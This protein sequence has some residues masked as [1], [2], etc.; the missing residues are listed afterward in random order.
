MLFLS[1]TCSC[2]CYC[3]SVSII[4]SL[5]LR[6]NLRVGG[7]KDPFCFVVFLFLLDKEK[8][9]FF[10]FMFTYTFIQKN[11]REL[12]EKI[13]VLKDIKIFKFKGW[14]NRKF[15]IFFSNFAMKLKFSVLLMK[16]GG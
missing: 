9:L 4:I 3:W 8:V 13:Y 7:E 16:L 6:E 2:C 15:A 14:Y 1:I 5:I 11:Q 12:Y 10:L